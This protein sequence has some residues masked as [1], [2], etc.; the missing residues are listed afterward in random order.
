MACGMAGE[1]KYQ[2][3][4]DTLLFTVSAPAI[5]EKGARIEHGLAI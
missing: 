4:C 3:S 1:K 2:W 5:V